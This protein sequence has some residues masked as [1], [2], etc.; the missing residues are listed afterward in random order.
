MSKNWRGALS[1]QNGSRQQSPVKK[2]KVSF[3]D[4]SGNKVYVFIQYLPH[5][6]VLCSWNSWKKPDDHFHTMVYHA[7]NGILQNVLHKPA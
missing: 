3:K 1:L 5:E 7:M 6:I 2:K 4:L